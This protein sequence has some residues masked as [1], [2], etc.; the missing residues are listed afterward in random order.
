MDEK[1][2]AQIITGLSA[3]C[4]G[5]GTVQVLAPRQVNNLFGLQMGSVSR[6]K[7]VFRALG[8]RDLMFAF[9]FF[10]SR[11]QPAANR[12]WLQAFEIFLLC[13]TLMCGQALTKPKANVFTWLATLNSI[14]FAVIVGWV[15]SRKKV[16][17]K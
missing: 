2:Q 9:G 16:T 7:V 13:D 3:V 11:S 1:T 14:L 17:N 6:Q 5:A 12:R 8:L 4:A 10:I 15:I